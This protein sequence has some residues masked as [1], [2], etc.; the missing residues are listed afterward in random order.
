MDYYF[1]FF[2]YILCHSLYSFINSITTGIVIKATM[3]KV[4]QQRRS[5]RAR[6]NPTRISDPSTLRHGTI[7]AVNEKPEGVLP[8]IDK[9]SAVDASERAWACACVSNLVGQDHRTR[10]LLLSRGLVDKLVERLTDSKLAV[11]VEA[12]GTLRNL[13]VL[14][15]YKV[16]ADMFSKNIL[17]A[18]QRLVQ[19]TLVTANEV[20]EDIKPADADAVA[21]HRA[22]W[23]LAE[24]LICI[25]WSLAETSPR[26]L[27]SVT[28]PEILSFVLRFLE[29]N[30][31]VPASLSI[32]AA[33][34]L[35]TITEENRDALAYFRS[36]PDIGQRLLNALPTG[37]IPEDRTVLGVLIAGILRNIRRTLPKRPDID[38]TASLN[39]SIAP[40]LL[41]FLDWDVQGAALHM[42]QLAPEVLKKHQEQNGLHDRTVAS[43]N[44]T[45]LNAMED[46]LAAMQ[47]CLEIL[48]NMASEDTIDDEPEEEKEDEWED[49]DEEEDELQAEIEEVTNGHA[50]GNVEEE[51]EDG[52]EDMAMI[53]AATGQ[54]VHALEE[55]E[56]RVGIMLNRDSG[57][58]FAQSLLPLLVRLAEPCLV[59]G[60]V[61]AIAFTYTR[62]EAPAIAELAILHARALACL[63]NYLVL[64]A[65]RSTRGWFNDQLADAQQLW[66][67]LLD[68][69]AARAQIPT[70]STAT[71]T[72]EESDNNEQSNIREEVL[73]SALDCLWS[74]ARGLGTHNIPA[75][76]TQIHALI[77]VAQGQTSASDHLRATCIGTLGVIAQRR[78]GYVEMNGII[79]HL[80]MTQLTNLPQT[81]SETA[82]EA[83]NALYDIYDDAAHDYD[84]PVF[85]KGGY[86]EA[87]RNIV[88]AVRQLTK[89]IDRRQQPALR[90]RAEE[91][92]VNLRAFIDYKT[93]E[94]AS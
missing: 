28:K 1:F 79:G 54:H 41:S 42:A 58:F 53:D 10:K 50:N 43:A 12:V 36:A 19:L 56:T 11:S 67:W 24:N 16:C 38:T 59:A 80:L 52:E 13:T 9:I 23:S 77:N 21:R 74:V 85:V 39:H 27:K 44:E 73:E 3:G 37:Q 18:M 82:I 15:G 30:T 49:L 25:Y 35:H 70:T 75:T 68:N 14:G 20:L 22:V 91:A 87:L 29:L 57:R 76:E 62:R 66:H 93:G 88:P 71:N 34:C 86:L 26:I 33:Q 65:E 31:K 4:K 94:T 90:E 72:N 40:I 45:Q 6:L 5:A 61:S 60:Q 2:F 64:A 81:P 48:A 69:V 47:L 89:R 92:L 78:P 51:E 83:L 84:A 55:A 8:V 63:N 7:R 46:R 32:I 17:T